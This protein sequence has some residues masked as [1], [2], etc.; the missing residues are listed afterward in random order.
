MLKSIIFG[1][2]GGL[3]LFLFGMKMMSEGLQSIAGK[4]LRKIL[5]LLTN[6]R[7]IAVI[8]G[9]IVTAIIQSSSATTVMVVGFCNAGLLTLVQAIGVILGA[10]I[11]TTIT[12]QIIA[13]KITEIALP[14]IGIGMIFY[15]FSKRNRFKFFGQTLLGF[16]LLFL[17]LTLMKDGA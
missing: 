8:V 12:A 5:E 1:L 15:L 3:G 2:L 11:G 7:I 4:Q 14:T 17:G 9:T 13:F 10:N 16:G 6:N